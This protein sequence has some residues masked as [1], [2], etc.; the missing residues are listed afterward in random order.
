[1]NQWWT[2]FAARIDALSLRERAVL[3]VTLIAGFVALADVLWLEPA[4]AAYQQAT[5]RF[6]TQ[7]TE[8]VR[9]RV[10]TQA[11]ANVVDPSRAVRADIAA[12]DAR[13]ADINRDIAGVAPAAEQ[14][15]R[16]EQ[17]LLQFLR[18]QE[19]MTLLGT[20]TMKQ[21]APADANAA[22]AGLS[23]RGMELRVSGTYADLTRYVKTLENA[24]PNLRWGQLQL[25]SDKQPPELTLQ[26]YVVGV[27]P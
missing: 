3:F 2:R 1:M 7:K 27:Q 26:V 14:G 23:K 19:G 20:S 13:L 11:G 25:K 15:P 9:L 6:E 21:D 5:T 12:A 16:L 18:R 17:V 4:Q 24:L 8:L 10:E 22:V